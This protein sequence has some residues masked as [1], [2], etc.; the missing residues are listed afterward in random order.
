M[1]K[2]L[3]VV[4]SQGQSANPAKR[5]LEEDLVAALLMERGVEVTVIPHLY[6]L[7]P[8]GTGMLCLQGITGDMVVLSWLY[9]RAARWVLDR[10]QVR[11]QEGATL[12]IAETDEDEDEDE[13]KGPADEAA[14]NAEELRGPVPNRKIYCIDLRVKDRPEPYVQE[15]R[16]IV[17]EMSVQTVDLLSWGQ[18]SGVRGQ[19]S[20]VGGQK[21]DVGDLKSQIS[22]LKSANPQSAQP[23]TL[24]PQPSTNLAIRNPQ[25]P[26]PDS[27]P[28]RIDEPTARR[29]YPVIDYSRC[30]NCMECLDFCLFGVYGVDRA[31]AIL[32]EQP[33]NCRKGCPACSRVCPENAIIFPQHKTP[34]IAGSPEV[35]AG[36][37]KIDLSKLFG[38]PDAI[39]IAAQERDVELVAVG[40]DAVGL[41]VGIPK[42]QEGKPKGPKDGLDSLMDQLDDLGL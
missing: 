42:R 28:V 33:D 11:G 7:A 24:N 4:I 8:D 19:E 36:G 25:S 26:T 31:E 23:S 38:A 41:T 18:G 17:A 37:F 39:E 10:N 12:L 40:R 14:G 5:G 22:D 35:S 29:W 21:S 15:I 6:D 30:T 27:F 2:R 13:D 9:P 3:T 20:E 16:R 34:A 1:A 32:V